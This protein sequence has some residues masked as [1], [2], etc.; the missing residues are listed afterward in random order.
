[1]SGAKDQSS[2]TRLPAHGK[3]VLIDI[4]LFY[5]KAPQTKSNAAAKIAAMELAR[6]ENLGKDTGSATPF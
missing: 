2:L 5:V 4:P 3:W 6:M 1:M